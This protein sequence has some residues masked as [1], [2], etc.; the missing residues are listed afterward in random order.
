[1]I[2]DG[3]DLAAAMEWSDGVFRWEPALVDAPLS[4]AG[5][6]ASTSRMRSLRVSPNDQ[7]AE[8]SASV[9]VDHDTTCGSS[10][11]HRTRF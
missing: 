9:R 1:M 4:V 7:G 2:G 5:D 11:G 10:L 8:A 6:F 3:R